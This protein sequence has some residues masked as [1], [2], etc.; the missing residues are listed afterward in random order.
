[1]T[2][3]NYLIWLL[4]SRNLAFHR[5][6]SV[7]TV[8]INKPPCLTK[9]NSHI[10]NTHGSALGKHCTHTKAIQLYFNIDSS[11]LLSP[12]LFQSS[13]LFSNTLTINY[14]FITTICPPASFLTLFSSSL[15][16]NLNCTSCSPSP[17]TWPNTNNN[18][19]QLRGGSKRSGDWQIGLVLCRGGF[20]FYLLVVIR[21]SAIKYRP[22][23]TKVCNP[24]WIIDLSSRKKIIHHDK[25]TSIK[26]G[27]ERK[28]NTKCYVT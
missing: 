2:T 7:A 21:L 5:L 24:R 6:L 15:V 14:L 16:N 20:S 18:T 12:R 25:I 17:Q 8:I 9:N 3:Y 4:F 1:M 23:S 28:T 10:C 22:F 19:V 13:C 27:E 11:C 26:S